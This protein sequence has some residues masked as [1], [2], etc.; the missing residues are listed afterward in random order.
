MTRCRWMTPSRI[1][2]FGVAA[3]AASAA[4]ISRAAARVLKTAPTRT[5]MTTATETLG[6]T[7]A[8]FYARRHGGGYRTARKAFTCGQ[9]G[10]FQ[11]IDPGV[12]YFDTLEVTTWS[13]T[14]RICACCA[15]TQV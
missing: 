15:E 12:R 4:M 3:H 5:S 6:T 8:T 13:K 7:R 11:K 1:R 14:K 9:F 2:R 10:C